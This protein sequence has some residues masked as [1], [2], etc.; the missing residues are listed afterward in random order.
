MNK[1]T[2]L[3]VEDDELVREILVEMLSPEFHIIEAI[4]G[5]HG[6]NQYQLYA[7]TISAVVTDLRMPKMNGAEMI[8]QLRLLDPKLPILVI[9][10]G[11]GKIDINDLTQKHQIKIVPKPFLPDELLG[12]LRDEI[13]ANS[14]AL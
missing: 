4:D 9:T 2:L 10:G 13:P 6:I 7:E 12:A 11:E 3:V 5:A 8:E 1:K 14:S